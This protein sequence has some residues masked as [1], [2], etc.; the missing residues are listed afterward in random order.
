MF[1]IKCGG[2]LAWI[3]ILMSVVQL[4]LGFYSVFSVVPANAPEEAIGALQKAVMSNSLADAGM[5]FV[6][7]VMVGLL[8]Q[9]AKGVKFD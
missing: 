6:V 4:C 5:Y 1:F 8:V 3:L 7:G 2:L 9:I